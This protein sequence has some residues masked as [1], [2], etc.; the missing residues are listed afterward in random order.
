M[1]KKIILGIFVVVALLGGIFWF[2]EKKLGV[3]TQPESISSVDN[4]DSRKKTLIYT[5]QLNLKF[6]LDILKFWGIREVFQ[7]PVNPEV[8]YYISNSN[9][10]K[11]ATVSKF[12]TSKVEDFL[13]KESYD[14][15]KYNENVFLDNFYGDLELRGV[16][17][18]GDKFVFA[19]TS[20]DN[21]PGPCFSPWFY[22]SL[23]Y[24]EVDSTPA[25]RKPYSLSNAKLTEL[26]EEEKRCRETL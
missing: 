12:D 15:P 20:R 10:G 4:G 1:D 23:N 3:S 9:A 8:F 5:E 24:I 22:E 21:S 19:K 26:K 11:S 17:F 13:H 25:V 6:S 7:Y 16:G 2:Q 18:D 14:L